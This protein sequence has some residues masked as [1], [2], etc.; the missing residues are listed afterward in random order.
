M[1]AFRGYEDSEGGSHSRPQLLIRQFGLNQLGQ[2]FLRLSKFA[3]T[4]LQ[5]IAVGGLCPS[6]MLTAQMNRTADGY[7]VWSHSYKASADDILTFGFCR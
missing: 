4:H 5:W 1:L 3:N 6:A 7:H 2:P